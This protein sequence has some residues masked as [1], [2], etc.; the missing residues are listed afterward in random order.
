MEDTILQW[1]K[2]HAMIAPGD[3]VMVGLSGGADSVALC[4][5]LHTHRDVWGI[6]LSALHFEHGLR[7]EESLQDQAFVEDFCSQYGIPLFVGKGDMHLRQKPPGHSTEEWARDLRYGFFASHRKGKGDKIALAHTQS[8]NG[9]TLLFHALRGSGPK[10]LGGI[11]P[12]RDFYIRPLLCLDRQEIETYCQTHA[13]RYVTDSTN[14]Q[15]TYTRNKIRNEIMPRLEH[16]HPGAGR[17]LA[18]LAADMQ[19]LNSWLQPLADQQLQHCL[20]QN[21]IYEQGST[22]LDKEKFLQVPVPLRKMIWSSLLGKS[23]DRRALDRAEAVLLGQCSAT[24]IP[25]GKKVLDR[26][27]SVKV[28]H[29]IP[30]QK[31]LQYKQPFGTGT[32]HFAGNY[33]LQ[34]LLF[35]NSHQKD[36][37]INKVEKDLFFLADYDRMVSCSVFRTRRT[38]DLFTERE[39][40]KPKLLKKWMSEKKIELSVR[41]LLPV[42]ATDQKVIWVCGHGFAQEFQPG[43]HTEKWIVIH[44]VR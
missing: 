41:D 29:Y 26:R 7:G 12:V 27:N 10:G 13:L 6:S 8:D 40:T 35:D 14:A 22:T 2:Q 44:W 25:G 28:L 38:G 23:A 9:E 15:N 16:I 43:S 42:L 17:N 4:H 36:E 20:L 39:N 19:Q 30:A 3:H 37:Y 34:I 31:D 18:K 1:I 33:N 24:E 32:Y 21:S 11:P 5:F